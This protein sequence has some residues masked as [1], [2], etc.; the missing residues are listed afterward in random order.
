MEPKEMG[1][2]YALGYALALLLAGLWC[3]LCKERAR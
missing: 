3:W 1:E 2:A